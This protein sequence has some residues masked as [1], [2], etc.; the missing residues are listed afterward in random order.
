[1]LY[2][3][4]AIVV[5]TVIVILAIYL[6]PTIIELKKTTASARRFLDGV[7]EDL[8]P[9]IKEL[10]ETASQVN[11]IASGAKEGVDKIVNFLDAVGSVGKTIKSINTIVRDRS[12]IFLISLA[13]LGVGIRKGLTVFLKGFLKGGDNNGR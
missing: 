4:L 6:I 3:I 5:S 10:K 7:E 11:G 8:R 13:A 1:M 12:G 9:L 2:D